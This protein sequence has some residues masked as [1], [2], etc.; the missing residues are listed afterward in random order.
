MKKSKLFISVLAAALFMLFSLGLAACSKEPAGYVDD[1]GPGGPGGGGG[2]SYTITFDPNGGTITGDNTRMTMSDGKLA[3]LPGR[4]VV[5]YTNHTFDGWYTAKTGGTEVTT[6]TVF[7]KN[8]TVYAHWTENIQS[9]SGYTIT[10]HANNGTSQSSQ[11]TTNASGVLTETAPTF[12]YDGY[13]FDGWFTDATGGSLVSATNNITKTFTADSDL[14]AQWTR[15]STG[16][17][18]SVVTFVFSTGWNDS[19]NDVR[20]HMWND[21]NGAYTEFKYADFS[22]YGGD[23]MTDETG[24]GKTFKYELTLDERGPVTGFNIT[25]RQNGSSWKVAQCNDYAGTF[26]G[27]NTYSFTFGTWITDAPNFNWSQDVV[28]FTLLQA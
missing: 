11:L 19:I 25:F 15:K 1:V 28:P 16:G 10:F 4:S 22:E 27:G 8:D 23:L 24:G 7:T 26:T 20:I 3:S 21:E 9:S 2:G 6:S 13:D 18:N 14:Y 5:K 12:S 17:L